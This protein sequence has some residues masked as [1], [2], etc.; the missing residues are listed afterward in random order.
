MSRGVAGRRGGA[1]LMLGAMA[2][3]AALQGCAVEPDATRS[4]ADAPATA[5]EVTAL[6]SAPDAAG[7][8]TWW[9]FF[10]DRSMAVHASGAVEA[11][12]LAG[13]PP[14]RAESMKVSGGGGD[15]PGGSYTTASVG[16][17]GGGR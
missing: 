4:S 7:Q 13:L 8:R 2:L 1:L 15:L 11:L 10:D 3:A 17:G 9:L 6:V 12:L 16:I 14:E 5:T